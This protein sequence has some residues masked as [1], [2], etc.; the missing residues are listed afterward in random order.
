MSHEKQQK[1]IFICMKTQILYGILRSLRFWMYNEEKVV[2]F[3]HSL[4]KNFL[5]ERILQCARARDS[6]IPYLNNEE[7]NALLSIEEYLKLMRKNITKNA[8]NSYER[9]FNVYLYLLDIDSQKIIT[10]IFEY[11]KKIK[12]KFCLSDDLAD[13]IVVSV[14]CYNSE[15]ET[16]DNALQIFKD[17]QTKMNL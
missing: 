10:Q 12:E 7:Y 4:N 15:M 13:Y 17:I 1:Q 6:S 9:N 3:D 11:T 8:R 2:S 5:D 16:L 14:I